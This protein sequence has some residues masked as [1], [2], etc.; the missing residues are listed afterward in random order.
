METT[1]EKMTANDVI[2]QLLARQNEGRR[3][4]FYESAENYLKTLSVGGKTYWR[5]KRLLENKP[6]ILKEFKQLPQNVQ[7]L[8][9]HTEGVDENVFLN[10]ETESLISE[11]LL[12]WNNK[13]IY[14][15][16]NLKVR[17][18]I[19]FHGATG[20]GKTTVAKYIAKKSGLAYFEVKP[21]TV[22]DSRL[23]ATGNNIQEIFNSINQPSILF[24]D[25][26]DSIGGIRGASN[27]GAEVENDRMTNS[28]L[29]NIEKLREDVVFIG[30]TNRME[31]LDSAFKRRFDVKH[32]MS[33]PAENEKARFA[34]QLIDWYKIPKESLKISD[35]KNLNSYSEISAALV[36]VARNI[37]LEKIKNKQ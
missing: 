23:G 10:Q 4:L 24:W 7:K 20:N 37:V 27:N 32:E 3:D 2:F 19:L 6:A 16:H 30:A 1:Q 21:D 17:H 14:K 25:E 9:N 36:S 28:I 33:A 35:F 34:Q 29:V 13:D 15:Q 26:I 5:I 8:L 31:F 18:K 22:I 11:L 12:E